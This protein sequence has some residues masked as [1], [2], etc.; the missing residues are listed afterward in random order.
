MTKDPSTNSTSSFTE[1]YPTSSALSWLIPSSEPQFPQ[2]EAHFLGRMVYKYASKLSWVCN[3]NIKSESKLNL[4]PKPQKEHNNLWAKQISRSLHSI[5]S[6]WSDH[7]SIHPAFSSHNADKQ[8]HWIYLF[9]CV[10]SSPNLLPKPFHRLS[11]PLQTL[12]PVN[13]FHNLH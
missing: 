11:F 3:I 9:I 2:H 7:P 10:P 8:A 4:C 5:S 1:G 6:S 12:K 13:H